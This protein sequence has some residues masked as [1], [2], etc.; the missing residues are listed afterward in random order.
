ME[1]THSIACVRVLVMKMRVRKDIPA[2]VPVP[3]G[4]QGHDPWHDG[5]RSGGDHAGHGVRA[6]GRYLFPVHQEENSTDELRDE[7]KAHQDEELEGSEMEESE[8]T[9]AP[10]AARSGYS[11]P[12]LQPALSVP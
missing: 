8:T 9:P 4:T 3:W 6:R 11:S 1:P 5:G 10:Q 7:D 12:P 2:P